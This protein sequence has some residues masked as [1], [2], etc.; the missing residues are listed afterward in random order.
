VAFDRARLEKIVGPPQNRTNAV[1][2]QIS[3]GRQTMSLEHS[4][5]LSAFPEL[6]IAEAGHAE[7]VVALRSTM[8]VGRDGDNDIVL[9]TMTVSRNHAVLLRDGAGTLLIDLESANGT[10]VN[11]QPAAPDE[12]VRLADGDTLQFGQVVARYSIPTVG[13]ADEA[14][15][16]AQATILRP[17]GR[18]DWSNYQ[19]LIAEAAAAHERGA[20]HLIVDLSGV[21]HLGAA[22]LVALHAITLIA[23]GAQPPDLEAGW[24]AIRDLAEQHTRRRLD[25]V[26][27]RAAIRQVLEHAPFCDFLAVHPDVDTALAALAATNATASSPRRGAPG[28]RRT[29]HLLIQPG[30]GRQQLHSWA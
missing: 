3:P 24:A 20:R 6:H 13:A 10:L 21:S 7:R 18:L 28:E 30:A 14:R 22:G 19:A 11:G 9:D 26:N 15:A 27:P 29:Q 8:T 4:D 16:Y 2:S 1:V 23:Q 17:L 25:V 5:S 12:P